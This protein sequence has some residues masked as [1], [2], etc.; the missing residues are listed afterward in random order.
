MRYLRRSFRGNN[1]KAIVLDLVQ[2]IA[3]GWQLIGF[4]G[5]ARHDEPGRQGTLQHNADSWT[6]A[7]VSTFF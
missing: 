6:I 3:A 1:P 4:G 2:P 5:K 7:R